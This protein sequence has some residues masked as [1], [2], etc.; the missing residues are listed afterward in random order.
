MITC[1][2]LAGGETYIVETQRKITTSLSGTLQPG[3]AVGA[4]SGHW[5]APFIASAIQIYTLAI[6]QQKCS[7]STEMHQTSSPLLH[8]LCL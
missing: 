1:T 6:L 2:P 8:S 4:A 5:R 7:G 3:E